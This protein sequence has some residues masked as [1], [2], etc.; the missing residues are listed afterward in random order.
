MCMQGRC[1]LFVYSVSCVNVRKV[2]Q[3]EDCV[4]LSVVIYWVCRCVSVQ[5]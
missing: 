5:V 1:R 2:S 4:V 3:G